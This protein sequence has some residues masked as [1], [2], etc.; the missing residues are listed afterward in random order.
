MFK[1]SIP[2]VITPFNEEKVD[3]NSLNKV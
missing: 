2:A 3:Y 1:G